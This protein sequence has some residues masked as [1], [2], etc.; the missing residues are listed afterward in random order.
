MPNAAFPARPILA[1]CAVVLCLLAC[2]NIEKVDKRPEPVKI[3]K[4]EKKSIDVD[5]PPIMRGTVA[6]EALVLGY[7]DVV[8]RGFG[9]VVGLH[10]TG[11]RQLPADVRAYMIQ[12][13]GRRGVGLPPLDRFTPDQLLDSL[14]T[15]V[16][17]V[18]GVVPAGAPAGTTF[19]V[20]VYAS[21]GTSTTSLEGGRLYTCD[22]RPGQLTTT[23]RQPSIVA[24][25]NGPVFVNPFVEPTRG[26]RTTGTV[27]AL[28]GRILDGGKVTRNMPLK[29]RLYT[30]SHNRAATLQASINSNFPREPGQLDQTAHG[31]SD[32]AVNIVIPRSYQGH[33][34]EFIE[35][36]R[37]T[38]LSLD[39]PEQIALQ[40]RRALLANPVSDNAAAWRWQALGVRALPMIQDLYAYPEDRPRM[41]ALRAG[42]GLNDALVA[43]PLVEMA[44]SG[45][46]ANRLLAIELLG[47]MGINPLIDKG[48]RDLMQDD[49]VDVRV[50]AFVALAKRR[51]P[52]VNMMPQ[53]KKFEL[54]TGPSKVPSVYISQSGTPRIAVASDTEVLLETP[55]TLQIWDN[56]LMIKGDVGDE[57]IEVFYRPPDSNDRV[58]ADAPTKLVDFIHFLAHKATVDQPK[59]GLDL[60][61]GE[62]VG[63]LHELWK[64]KIIR[65]DF[66][67]EQ[68]RLLAAI[69]DL[70][71]G[72][73]DADRPEFSDP[74][75]D[76]LHEDGMAP[77]E[78][79]D[80]SQLE[81]L[82]GSTKPDQPNLTPG[83]GTVPRGDDPKGGIVPR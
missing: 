18:E 1:A 38:T 52:S 71:K 5:V 51:D 39:A 82:D 3:T 81:P 64:A 21:P 13:M 20:R 16:V 56:R 68:D 23:S 7:R 19:D 31:E 9:L 32:S 60:S 53:G 37:H 42:A 67:T 47:E 17:V 33:T 63:V 10:G 43:G 62:V 57:Q 29:I 55:I 74:D 35:L 77:G 11:S 12:E 80:G 70:D 65:V 26:G 83:S 34:R 50:A 4:P 15:A 2:D 28:S 8:V 24:S 75:F 30:P 69:L 22:L 73:D 46:P 54:W 27:T 59:P 6:A 58:I 79:T 40:V 78:E 44:R 25:A 72:Q 66:K 41:A 45:N 49:D 36:M 48:L 14:D 76:F 61:Y